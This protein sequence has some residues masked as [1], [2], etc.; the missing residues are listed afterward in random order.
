MAYIYLITNDING[1]QYIGKTEHNDLKERWHE[2]LNDYKRK[3]CEKR[4]LYSAMNYYGP[5]HFHIKEIEYISSDKNLEEREIYW[6]EK[7]DTYHNGYNA[8]KGGDGKHYLDYDLIIK[9]YKETLNCNKTAKIVG[10]SPDSVAQIVKKYGFVPS[11]G[12]ANSKAVCQI[13]LK[14]GKVIAIFNSAIE[15]EKKLGIQNHI[16]AVCKG[17]RKSAGGYGWKYLE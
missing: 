11:V 13:D 16:N 9:I 2:H 14:T 5:E 1:K 4:P 6:I 8:T 15:A 12:A 3:R 10:C 17:N 7:Y